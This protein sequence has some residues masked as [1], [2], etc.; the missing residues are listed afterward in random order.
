MKKILLIT[1]GFPYMPGEKPFLWTELCHL[2]KQF[3]VNIVARTKRE[4]ADVPECV[5]LPKNVKSYKYLIE[6]ITIKEKL[7]HFLRIICSRAWWLELTKLFKEHRKK[8]NFVDAYDYLVRSLLFLDW[9]NNEITLESYDVIY[10]YW[11]SF[12]TL[13]ISIYKSHHRNVKLITRTHG[14]DLYNERANGNRQCYKRYVNKYVDRV[15]F[16]AS[17]GKEYYIEHFNEGIN[18]NERLIVAPIG[19][20]AA[21][22]IPLKTGYKLL[23]S[24]SRMIPL[25]RINLV[26]EALSTIEDIQINWIHLGGGVEYDSINQLCIEKLSTKDNIVYKLLGEM[27]NEEVREFYD[28]DYVDCF[29]ST[30]ETEG[31]PVSM[32][33]ALAYGIP[34]IGTNVGEV[35]ELTRDTGILLNSN[36]K[37]DEIA[38]AIKNI[39]SMDEDV[40]SKLRD[41]A[42][43]KWQEHYDAEKNAKKF[44]RML[45]HLI[46]VT[47]D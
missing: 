38:D 42:Y 23:V 18:E 46:G 22:R 27:G 15:F 21:S 47:V 24:C 28:S 45:N 3:D 33:E 36:P 1:D 10:T 13:A 7:K 14:Y 6:D 32:Q 26:V 4:Y 20:S 17:S 30:S 11:N 5:E 37:I 44:I 41:N 40:V 9:I 8:E 39:F 35:E 25:K 12:A 19:A 31:S 16:I 43:K 2:S 29:I 34:I